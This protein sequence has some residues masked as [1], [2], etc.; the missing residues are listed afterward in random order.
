MLLKTR[1]KNIE[2]NLAVMFVVYLHAL[3]VVSGKY[4]IDVTYDSM[5]IPKTPFTVQ[6]VPGFDATRCKAYGPGRR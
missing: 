3:F 5:P 2:P 1:L 4:S 6:A